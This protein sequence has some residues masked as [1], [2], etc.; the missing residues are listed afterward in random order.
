MPNMYLLGVDLGTMGT[1]AALYDESGHLMSQSYEESV[2]RYPKVGWVEQCL[3]DIYGS[4]VRCIS[5][6]LEKSNIPSGNIEAIA[7]SSQMSGIGMINKNWEPV[8]HYDSWLDTRCESSF[9]LMAQIGEKITEYSGCPPTYAHAAKIIWWKNEQPDVFKHIDKFVVPSTYV[10]GKMAGLKSDEA[11]IDLTCLHFSGFSDSYRKQWSNEL[12]DYFD[13]PKEKMPRIVAPTDIIGSVTRDV[14]RETGL[15]EGT[16]IVAGAGDTAAASIGAGVV[17]PGDVFDNAGTASVFSMCL[18]EFVP[19][20]ENQTVLAAHGVIPGTFYALS[21]INGGGLNL[22]WF[23]D[24]FGQ[25]EQQVAKEM[26]KEVYQLFDEM[27]SEVQPG[28]EGTLFIPHLQ[29][30]VLPPDPSFRGQWLGFTWGHTKKHLFRAM[31][32]AVAYEYAYYLQIEKKMHTTLRFQEVRVVGGG[33]ASRLWNQIKSD[34]L[35]IPYCRINRSEVG[36]WGN[37]MIAGKAVGIY[38]DLGEIAQSS[39][40]VTERIEPRLEYHEHYKPYVEMYRQILV[41]YSE[42]FKHLRDLPLEL[43]NSAIHDI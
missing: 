39:T 41:D 20:T 26:E 14:A 43:K 1:K 15:K 27:A 40:E 21:F 2:L 23:R 37:A 22:R 11:Y 31:L 13:I 24:E 8:A 7:F 12:L 25:I 28:S 6:V 16:P 10:A 18:D 19:D 9:P 30:R 3:E 36:T 4:A 42:R 29:G 38:E 32:E 34:V 17:S 5:D 35:N 33:A